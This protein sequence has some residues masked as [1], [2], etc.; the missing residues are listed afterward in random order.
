M[1]L[2]VVATSTV[3]GALMARMPRYRF[4]GTAAVAT[5]IVGL[6]LLSQVDMRTS[7]LEVTRDIVII[8]AGLGVTFPLTIAVV[9]AGLPQQLL[10]VATSQVT[11]WRSLGGTMGVAILGSILSGRLTGAIRAKTAGLQLP[12]GLRLGG[13][14]SSTPQ[15]LLDPAHLT[16]VKATLP[17]QVVPIFDQFVVAIRSA[18]ASTLH[19]LFLIAAVIAVVAL[20]A[21]VFLREVP[22]NRAAIASTGDLTVEEAET[23]A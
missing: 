12:P 23:A 16:Q 6:V 4:L 13:Q 11:F 18:L 3:A 8:G 14:S 15:T 5:M 10:G 17:P 19:D 20:I 7:S 1:M 9:Q 2:A 22:L 21:T